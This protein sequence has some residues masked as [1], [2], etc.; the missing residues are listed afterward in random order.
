ME[1]LYLI[2]PLF[3]DFDLLQP[4]LVLH[5][6]VKKELLICMHQTLSIVAP[7]ILREQS[8]FFDQVVQLDLSI[9][10]SHVVDPGC[11]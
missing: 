8:L 10:A 9:E 1:I 4:N 2:V 3:E 7:K 5:L 11:A 6:V